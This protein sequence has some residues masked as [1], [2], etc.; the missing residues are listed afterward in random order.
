MLER[1][2]RWDEMPGRTWIEVKN[3]VH[4]FVEKH[5][6]HCQIIEFMPYNTILFYNHVPM[7]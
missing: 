4:M 6:G 7:H 5:Q 2:K 1:G 3:E